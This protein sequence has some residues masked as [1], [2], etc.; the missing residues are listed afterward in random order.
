[1]VPGDPIERIDFGCHEMEKGLEH[2]ADA[3]GQLARL[4]ESIHRAD[5]EE[6]LR[7]CAALRS[8]VHVAALVLMRGATDIRSAAALLFEHEEAGA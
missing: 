5:R 6:G 4:V 2:L 8:G 1:M 3:F 7:A